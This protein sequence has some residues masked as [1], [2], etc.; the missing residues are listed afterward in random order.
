VMLPR[1]YSGIMGGSGGAEGGGGMGGAGS[2]GSAG[3]AEDVL[4]DA[5]LRSNSLFAL[6]LPHGFP[7][8]IAAMADNVVAT[9][10]DRERQQQF[11]VADNGMHNSVWG[12][13]RGGTTLQQG[14]HGG[15]AESKA[16]GGG[17][18]EGGGREGSGP[19]GP[20][21]TI[22]TPS[23]FVLQQPGGLS[24]PLPS[25][26]SSS[27]SSS[28]SSSASPSPSSSLQTI[29]AQP[30]NTAGVAGPGVPQYPCKMCCIARLLPTALFTPPHVVLSLRPS[31]KPPIC[32]IVASLRD[33]ALS[34]SFFP[35][36]TSIR[37]RRD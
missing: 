14:A 25:T 35:P 22:G 34:Q 6:D 32:H 10:A 7:D 21:Y 15:D 2:A 30:S 36:K 4:S 8:D 24:R 37:T 26:S 17:E 20:I 18:G 5:A 33:D 29:N 11:A 13:A 19:R 12:C 16:G 1:V 23:Q 27:S 9:V 28:A 31:F 3:G